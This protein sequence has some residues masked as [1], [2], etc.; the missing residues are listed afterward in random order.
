MQPRGHSHFTP[1]H[2]RDAKIT[3]EKLSSDIAAFQRAGGKIEK[4]GNT[5]AMKRVVI[6]QAP[7][8]AAEPAEGGA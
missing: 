2:A 7:S 4:L 6:E 8:G 3:E 1:T 5:P